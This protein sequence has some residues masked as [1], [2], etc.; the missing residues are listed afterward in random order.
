MHVCIY[1]CA[2]ACLYKLI[3]YGMNLN[4]MNL[5][6]CMYQWLKEEFLQWLK[7]RE[8]NVKKRQGF[9]PAQQ[10]MMLLSREGL[11]IAGMLCV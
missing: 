8:T 4:L 11:E 10:N 3:M 6:T 5:H 1:L 2:C 7:E 9:I